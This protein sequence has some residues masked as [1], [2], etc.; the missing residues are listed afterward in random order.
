MEIVF[1]T[2]PDETGKGRVIVDGRFYGLPVA[3]V[4]ELLATKNA[5]WKACGDDAE[6]VA[7]YI[8]SQRVPNLELTREPRSGESSERSER[9]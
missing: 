2:K 3:A 4:S 1:D 7:E 8:E 6:M 5:L 9:G